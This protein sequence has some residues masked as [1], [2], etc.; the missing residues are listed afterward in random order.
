MRTLKP[1][2]QLVS[3]GR[4]YEFTVGAQHALNFLT[5]RRGVKIQRFLARVGFRDH[6]DLAPFKQGYL[7]VSV[8]EK[9]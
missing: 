1:H 8:G 6:S 5:M 2:F 9:A 3:K 4:F 7:L